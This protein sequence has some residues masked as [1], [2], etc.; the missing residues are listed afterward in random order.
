MKRWW[1]GLTLWSAVVGEVGATVPQVVVSIKPVHSL[2]AGVMAGVGEPELLVS[3]GASPHSYALKPSEVAS[4]QRAD[5]V[6]WLGPETEPFLP[7]F[8][9]SLPPSVRVTALAEARGVELLAPRTGD[10]AHS[11]SGGEHHDPH[12]WLSPH[13]AQ[14]MVSTIVQQLVAVDPDHS[15]QYLSN[16]QAL[17]GRLASLDLELRQ[18]LQP[19]QTVPYIVFHD[20][21]QYFEK[22]YGLQP[23]D[24]IAVNPERP[25]GAG[26]LRLIRERLQRAEARCIFTEPQFPPK[27]V[28]ALT[29]GL[30]VQQGVLD[31]LGADLQDGPDLYFVLLQNLGQ[32]FVQCLQESGPRPEAPPASWWDRM[33]A[34]LTGS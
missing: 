18:Q 3:G 34:L 6:F 14:G 27:L 30:T 23:V 16:L 20:A 7:K 31:P 9:Q 1:L 26:H 21:Y 19:L 17:Q 28:T 11:E 5:L 22:R 4:L 33:K 15:A 25:P 24:W 29:D 12:L 8:L 13:N 32:S 10:D 2:V